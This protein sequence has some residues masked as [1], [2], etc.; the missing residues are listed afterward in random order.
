MTISEL[1]K[2]WDS[3]SEQFSQDSARIQEV[4]THPW[5]KRSDLIPIRTVPGELF[6]RSLT[7]IGIIGMSIGKV[8][9]R[10]SLSGKVYQFLIETF[11]LIACQ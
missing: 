4:Y 7:K 1:T 5:E 11:S 6:P 8:E 9:A 3:Y 2:K 10:E